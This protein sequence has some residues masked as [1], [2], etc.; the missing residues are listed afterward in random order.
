MA[1]S[2]TP[3]SQRELV[4]L[5]FLGSTAISAGCFGGRSGRRTQHRPGFGK[6]VFHAQCRGAPE[7]VLGSARVD[8]RVSWFGFCR[9]V[10]VANVLLRSKGVALGT[11]SEPGTG[12]MVA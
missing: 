8:G 10:V 6:M 1:W 5:V 9:G 2:A 7:R 12:P 4:V 3:V 11:G